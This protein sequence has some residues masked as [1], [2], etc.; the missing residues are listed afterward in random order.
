MYANPYAMRDCGQLSGAQRA[1]S[2]SI[3]ASAMVVGERASG[4]CRQDVNCGD[5]FVTLGHFSNG[6]ESGSDE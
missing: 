2:W 4:R 5:K 3:D 6:S 1:K